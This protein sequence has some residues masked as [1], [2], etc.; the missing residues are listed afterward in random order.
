MYALQN[1]SLMRHSLG[2]NMFLVKL[3]M[4]NIRHLIPLE[5]VLSRNCFYELDFFC[6]TYRNCRKVIAGI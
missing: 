6:L 1:A 5:V 2:E 3:K 4:G